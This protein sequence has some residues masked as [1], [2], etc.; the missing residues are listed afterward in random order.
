LNQSCPCPVQERLEV[1]VAAPTKNQKSWQFRDQVIPSRVCYLLQKKKISVKDLLVM[2]VVNAL[3]K[4]QTD[5]PGSGCWATNDYLAAASNT[6][7]KYVAQRLS[8]L[9]SIGIMLIIDNHEG[10]RYLELEWSRTAEER[11]SVE[12]EYG[13]KLRKAYKELVDGIEKMDGILGFTDKGKPNPYPLGKPNPQGKGKPNPI[14]KEKPETRR[15]GGESPP[16]KGK[17]M[18]EELKKYAAAVK[19][20]KLSLRDNG[21]ERK[22][23]NYETEAGYLQKLEKTIKTD[24]IPI[25]DWYGKRCSFAERNR[26]GG[27]PTVSSCKEF[28][29]RGWVFDKIRRIRDKV[30]KGTFKVNQT[31]VGDTWNTNNER[32]DTEGC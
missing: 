17:P 13:V 4:T 26:L 1:S 32:W 25:L 3:V 24:P 7:P 15:N 9:K 14:Y 12:G 19:R 23:D 28:I 8:Y 5:E 20:L 11:K 31:E 16:R 2:F 22:F 21:Q 18:P 30:L 10:R 6:H 27:L 29:V